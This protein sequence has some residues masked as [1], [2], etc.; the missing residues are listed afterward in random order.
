MRMQ[1][2][3]SR[4]TIKDVKPAA[5]GLFHVHVDAGDLLSSYQVPGQYVQ[6]RVQTGSRNGAAGFA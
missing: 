5:E 1:A 3:F 2:E 6:V 4:V